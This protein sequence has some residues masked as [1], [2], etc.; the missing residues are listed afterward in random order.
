MKLSGEFLAGPKREGLDGQVLKQVGDQIRSVHEAGVQL[1][2]VIGGG[3][4]FRGLSGVASGMDRVSADQMGMLA[5]VI[6]AMALQDCLERLDVPVRVMTAVPMEGTAERFIRRK[7]IRHLERARVLILA[8]GTGNPFFTTDTAAALR[9]AELQA[10]VLLKATRVDGVFSADPE[11]DPDATLYDTITYKD[12]LSQNLRI[13]DST[14]ITL[15][16]ENRTPIVVFNMKGNN[17]VR[18]VRSEDVGTTVKEA[19]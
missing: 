8:G 1:G 16:M 3:N 19:I 15:C 9:A 2:I 6:N 14:A 13:M 10:D 5:T 17:L 12:V 18:V 7:A 4:I 11:T